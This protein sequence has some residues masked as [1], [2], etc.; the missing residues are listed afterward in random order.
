[1]Y[2]KYLYCMLVEAKYTALKYKYLDQTF[3]TVH[4]LLLHTLELQLYMTTSV[5]KPIYTC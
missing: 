2:T 3:Y 5:S 1:M 4:L